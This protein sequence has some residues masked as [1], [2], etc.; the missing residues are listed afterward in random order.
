[1]SRRDVHSLCRWLVLV[2]GLGSRVMNRVSSGRLSRL[3]VMSRRR[4]GSGLVVLAATSTIVFIQ[5]E[6]RALE[7]TN[8]DTERANAPM[9]RHRRPQTACYLEDERLPNHQRGWH[10]CQPLH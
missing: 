5:L 10:E 3:V 8:L 4:S 1:V 9:H 6:D 7:S 2:D